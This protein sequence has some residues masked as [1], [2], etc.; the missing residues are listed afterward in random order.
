MRALLALIFLAACGSD[1]PA[2]PVDAHALVACDNAWK[3]NGYTECEAACVDSSIALHAQ[4]VACEA[5]TSQGSVNCSKTFVFAGITGCCISHDPQI[6]FG[7]C[8]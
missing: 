7:E 5:T 1:D 6:L 3:I 8:N 4:G 2:G